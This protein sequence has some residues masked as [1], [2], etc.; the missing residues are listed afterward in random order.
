M[1]AS[2]LAK[3]EAL[4]KNHPQPDI[5]TFIH[6]FFILLFNLKIFQLDSGLLIQDVI[7]NIHHID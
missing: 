3:N 4:P 6:A 1:Q 7:K 2:D 5:L